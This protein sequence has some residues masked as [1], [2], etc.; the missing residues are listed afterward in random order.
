[1]ALKEEKIDNTTQPKLEDTM[2]EAE[3]QSGS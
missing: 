2:N 1:M 3:L